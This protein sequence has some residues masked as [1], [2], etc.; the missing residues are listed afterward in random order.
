[1]YHLNLRNTQSYGLYD[2]EVPVVYGIA[3][4]Y[5]VL[6][7]VVIRDI[8]HLAVGVS[9]IVQTGF[10]LAVGM[11]GTSLNWLFD[12]LTELR[13]ANWTRPM[14]S[15]EHLTDGTVGGD[16]SCFVHLR[17]SSLYL[18]TAGFPGIT[19]VWFAVVHLEIRCE[20]VHSFMWMFITHYTIVVGRSSA[21]GAGATGS[22][23]WMRSR[24]RIDISKPSLCCV[25]NKGRPISNLFPV[26]FVGDLRASFTRVRCT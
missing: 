5:R 13:S 2:P 22:M 16:A 14:I 18:A 1:M 26:L 19:Q 20:Q 8:A 4:S 17:K 11:R 23:Y 7:R 21:Y 12:I 6:R 3:E 25:S 10:W 9:L 15:L 24:L